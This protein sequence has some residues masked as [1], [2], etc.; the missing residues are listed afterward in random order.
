MSKQLKTI[1]Q[2]LHQSFLNALFIEVGEA[3]LYEKSIFIREF[4][5]LSSEEAT[6]F[7]F[8]ENL[9]L[10]GIA[11][12]S[13]TFQHEYI[14]HYFVLDKKEFKE[15]DFDHWVEIMANHYLKNDKEKSVIFLNRVLKS[16]ENTKNE[17]TNLDN[18]L[19]EPITFKKSET[20]LT[21]GHYA[22]PYPKL[23]ETAS[24]QSINLT[25]P[26]PIKWLLIKKEYLC[27]EAS[28]S[29]GINRAYEEIISIANS[30]GVEIHDSYLPFP[31]HPLQLD[32]LKNNKIKQLIEN[33]IILETPF[34]SLLHPTT[35]L[36]SLY[37]ENRPWMMKFSLSVRLTNSIR[38]L[39][40]HEVRRGMVLHDISTAAKI[41][42]K[43]SKLTI[44]H[45][46]FFMAL[47]DSQDNILEESI[48]VFRENLFLPK[49]KVI[50]LAVLTQELPKNDGAL[51]SK[52]LINNQ[53]DP[54]TWYRSN[55]LEQVLA[56]LLEL[57]STHGILL[58]AHQQN[59]ILKMDDKQ[60]VLQTYYR[61]TQGSGFLKNIHQMFQLE[62]NE[63]TQNFIPQEISNMLVGYYL[64]INS[65]LGTI[66]ALTQN[67]KD[68]NE[69]IK[70]TI[71]FL[72]DSCQKLKIENTNFITFLLSSPKL[73]IKNNFR[74]S[75]QNENENAMNN[76]FNLY[77]SI[78]N[79]FYSEEFTKMHTEEAPLY[80]LTNNVSHPIRP[81]F[82]E[83]EILYTQDI[84]HLQRTIRLRV[85]DRKLDLDTFH[86]WHNQTRV[87]HFWELNQSKTELLG[88]ISKS[89]HDPHLMPVIAE[90][91]DKNQFEPVGYFEIYW[92]KE[93]RLGPYYDAQDYDRGFHLLIGNQKYLGF[94]NTD[95]ILKHVCHYIFQSEPKTESIMGE[96]RHDNEKILKYLET[97]K[98]WERIKEFD[99]PHK[100]AVL[101]RCDRQK[102]YAGNYL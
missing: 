17:I 10:I 15:V 79:P 35:S 74:C 20:M 83:G 94:E 64:M 22:H 70:L 78:S 99:F 28:K 23:R 29:F 37:S 80:T 46:P 6:H 8:F 2:T 65:T 27:V 33:K 58:G 39:K 82:S 25:M 75:L 36:R 44:L 24:D 76:P 85:I 69:L 19:K 72:I 97:F 55:Y 12:L 18:L 89:L 81:K 92:T 3:A 48:V 9:F 1:E 42:T 67:A 102:F 62:V 93:D 41:A 7:M 52:I 59:I 100:R 90:L 101:L 5:S 68:E 30:E 95:A 32:I 98:A 77:R 21:L 43:R 96:P 31:I 14:N 51:L 26:T 49:E 4:P 54:L 88:Y 11:R 38:H 84:P 66:R 63:L 73:K 56:P 60:N 57:Q 91:G 16:L 13:Q 86:E 45:E 50:S 34:T 71:Q 87:A 47:K 53:I 40:L 61:D